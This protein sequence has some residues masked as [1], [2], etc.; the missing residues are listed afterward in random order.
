MKTLKYYLIFLIFFFF[1][2]NTEAQRD[3]TP[4]KTQFMI[5]GYGS[6]GYQA[7][8][9]EGEKESTF[10]SGTFAPIMLFKFS[11]KLFFEAELEFEYENGELETGLE[12]ADISYVM[13]KYMTVRAGKFLLPFGTFMER[14]HPSWINKLTTIPLGFGHDGIAPSSGIGVEVRG[15]FTSSGS[16]FNYSL[17]S[18]NGPKLNDGL[19]EPDE[20]GILHFDNYED[21]NRNKAIGGRIGFFPFTDSSTELGFSF[22]NSTVG[23]KES[24]Y[25]DV[26]ANLY[27]YDFSFI[28]KINPLGGIIDVKAQLNKSNVDGATYIEMHDDGDEE[29]YT[30][31]NKSDSFFTQ[32]SYKPSMSESNFI[33]NLEFVGRYSELETPMGSEWYAKLKQKTFGINY[34]LSWRSAIKFNYQITDGVGGHGGGAVDKK[35]FIIQWAIG[36]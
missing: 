22:L 17:Y 31:N 8:N 5:R 16:K 2:I 12:Y 15:A 1:S 21:N 36:F 35:E 19:D 33:K 32:L 3:L 34:W 7:I 14:Y 13:N 26:G 4:S 18:T 20:A 11:E 24:I 27:A 25:E 9:D 29:E 6:A 30:F 28:K 23:N 10:K